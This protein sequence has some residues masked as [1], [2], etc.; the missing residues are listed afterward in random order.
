[1]KKS[2][3]WWEGLYIFLFLVGIFWLG[4]LFGYFVLGP[5]LL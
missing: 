1:M 3:K 4:C 5:A 2:D